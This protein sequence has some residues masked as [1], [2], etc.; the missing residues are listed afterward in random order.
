MLALL[1]TNR[2]DLIHAVEES[3]FIAIAG[4]ILYKTPY[5][6]D[7]DSSIPDQ[8]F[9]KYPGLRLTHRVLRRIERIMIRRSVFVVAVCESLAKI[10][11]HSMVES[12]IAILEDVPLFAK[13]EEGKPLG[14]AGA[15]GIHGSVVMYVGNL[16]T[17]QGIDLLLE[18]FRIAHARDGRHHLVIV[19]GADADIARYTE[20]ARALGIAGHV[21]FLGPKPVEELPKYLAEADILVSPRTR[22]ENTP[23]KIYSYMFSGKPILATR[24]TTHTQVLNDDNSV[25]ADPV[26]G[27]FA[28]ALSELLEDVGKREAIGRRAIRDI[29]ERY[30]FKV[31]KGKL[32]RIYGAIAQDLGITMG[33]CREMEPGGATSMGSVRHPGDNG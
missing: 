31:Y 23:M 16:E 26:P 6:F 20:M 27:P 14:L 24:M 13:R 21:H 30:S 29:E 8:I 25:L 19:G 18:S 15:L 9:E 28:N 4:K 12:R 5:V 17:Y 32:S 10:A 11:R 33:A 3:A 2:Y 22:G 7:M 1:R